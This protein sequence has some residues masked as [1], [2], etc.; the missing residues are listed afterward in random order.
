MH[1]IA[2]VLFIAF[3]SHLVTPGFRPYGIENAA[4]NVPFA[5]KPKAIPYPLSAHAHLINSLKSPE[6]MATIVVCCLWSY[7]KI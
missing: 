2:Y 4:A 5:L 6:N 3:K 7:T 1:V